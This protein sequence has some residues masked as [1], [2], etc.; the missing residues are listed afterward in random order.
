MLE[1][2]GKLSDFSSSE[3]RR[4]SDFVERYLLNS[5]FLEKRTFVAQSSFLASAT[6][7]DRFG[8]CGPPLVQL[9]LEALVSALLAGDLADRHSPASR[10]LFEE[11]TRT[12]LVKSLSGL[13]GA[14]AP[15]FSGPD[16]NLSQLT[17]TDSRGTLFFWE[18]DS[19]GRR[20]PMGLGKRSGRAVL[21]GPDLELPLANEP[22]AMALAE[23]TILPGLAL[24]YLVLSS[25]GLKTH[26][27]VFMIDYLPALLRPAA[28]ILEV[29][30]INAPLLDENLS[31]AP[32]EEISKDHS[33]LERPLLAAGILP[34]AVADPLAPGGFAAAGALEMAAASPFSSDLLNNLASLKVSQA[35][36]F[37]LGEWYQEETPLSARFS[38]W[39][40]QL[41][42]P[43]LLLEMI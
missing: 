9:E 2:L 13:R 15:E 43:A 27:G 10:V 5:A 29:P 14:W 39:E 20:H 6:W 32:L 18:A 42:Q 8:H 37:S 36:P 21:R 1:R 35:L 24:D 23:K 3:K 19:S 34:L 40:A 22:I 4:T 17:S 33:L 28:A 11:K 26:G 16:V 41:G 12:A 7:A 38:G 31:Q 30:L 25:H